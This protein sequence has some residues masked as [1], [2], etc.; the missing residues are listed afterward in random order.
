VDAEGV[1]VK[2]RA[3]PVRPHRL[4]VRHYASAS[5]GEPCAGSTA[6]RGRFYRFAGLPAT[7][8]LAARLASP[9]CA[10]ATAF[11]FGL[12]GDFAFA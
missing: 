11:A 6:D 8:D 12:V 4:L 7:A 1:K 3:V 5:S 10:L 9:L 2:V